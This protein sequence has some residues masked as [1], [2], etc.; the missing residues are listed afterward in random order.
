M[1]GGANNHHGWTEMPYE[2]VGGRRRRPL[3]FYLARSCSHGSALS[4]FCTL[5]LKRI[6]LTPFLYSPVK[7]PFVLSSKPRL[8][9]W[10]L[11]AVCAFWASLIRRSFRPSTLLR[12]S[13][14]FLPLMSRLAWW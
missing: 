5:S 4:I 10:A 9:P 2:A 3:L 14:C 7:D 12:T 11:L 6:C 1:I 13:W 8:F